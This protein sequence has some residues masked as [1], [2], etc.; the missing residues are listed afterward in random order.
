MANNFTYG[1]NGDVPVSADYDGDGRSDV[2]IWRPSTA[3]FY[4]LQSASNTS[5]IVAWGQT[6]DIPVASAFVR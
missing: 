1:L 4:V 2:A 5:L 6:T 3:T